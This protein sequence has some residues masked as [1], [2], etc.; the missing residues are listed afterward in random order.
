MFPFTFPDRR[1]SSLHH[2]IIVELTLKEQID[3]PVFRRRC[4]RISCG[5]GCFGTAWFSSEANRLFVWFWSHCSGCQWRLW[6]D[7]E[8]VTVS[9]RWDCSCVHADQLRWCSRLR[10]IGRY[11]SFGHKG[12]A[13]FSVLYRNY[14]SQIGFY[15]CFNRKMSLFMPLPPVFYVFTW[16][17]FAIYFIDRTFIEV[18]PQRSLS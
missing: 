8:E 6:A 13:F 7:R 14:L 9:G 18:S 17:V 4:R 1:G 2:V 16:V 10:K 12:I 11:R 3:P 15:S 5:S